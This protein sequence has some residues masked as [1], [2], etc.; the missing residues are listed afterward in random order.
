[1]RYACAALLVAIS[2]WNLMRSAHATD[3]PYVV[4]Q[5]GDVTAAIVNNEAV[6]DNVLPGHRADTVAW[7]R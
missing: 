7:L 6:D 3:K 5:R 2:P 4:L 1:M